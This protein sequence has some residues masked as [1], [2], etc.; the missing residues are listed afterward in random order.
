[1]RNMNSYYRC[2]YV[3]SAQVEW[4]CANQGDGLELLVGGVSVPVTIGKENDL[5]PVPKVKGQ[6][7][8]DH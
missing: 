1:M 7:H 3:K 4:R 8:V 5:D 6:R 2:I